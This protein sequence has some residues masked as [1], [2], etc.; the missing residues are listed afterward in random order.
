MLVVHWSCKASNINISSMSEKT[1]D[2]SPYHLP[3]CLY[4]QFLVALGTSIRGYQDNVNHS[5]SGT[6]SKFPVIVN[7]LTKGHWTD[8]FL[9]WW[10]WGSLHISDKRAH[11]MKDSTWLEFMGNHPKCETEGTNGPTKWTLGQKTFFRSHF[12]KIFWLHEDK[13]S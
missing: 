13:I 3:S 9:I 6:R 2:C 5:N 8:I 7:F 1:L 4:Y 10:L 11:V 12:C